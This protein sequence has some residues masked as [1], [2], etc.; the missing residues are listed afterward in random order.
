METIVVVFFCLPTAVHANQ[1]PYLRAIFAVHSTFSSLFDLRLDDELMMASFFR[2]RAHNLL[3]VILSTS[4]VVA[5]TFSILLL[6][7]S[8][9]TTTT[10]ARNF[11]NKK[12]VQRTGMI[13]E[14]VCSASHSL[15][16]LQS[17]NLCDT[18]RESWCV[19]VNNEARR[20]TMIELTAADDVN[21][22]KLIDDLS[23]PTDS[24]WLKR[25][26]KT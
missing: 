10:R 17:V 8:M 6:L 15:H 2:V 13:Y 22:V 14:Q 23:T 3:L 16:R 9:T 25:I 5:A 11:A 1:L 18:R 24:E 4:L 20:I 7:R 21:G 26:P 12:I 19:Q